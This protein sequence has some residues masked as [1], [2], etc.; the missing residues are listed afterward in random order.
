MIDNSKEYVICAAI[1]YKHKFRTP[2]PRGFIAQNLKEGMVIGQWRHGNCIYTHK[3]SRLSRCIGEEKQVQGFLT[4]KGNFVDRWQGMKIAYEAGQ[5]S[6][7]RAFRS[8]ARLDPD[9]I[10][11]EEL[12]S[13]PPQYRW[14]KMRGRYDMMYSEDL[15]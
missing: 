12:M 14:G 3:Q 4:S 9:A 15:Y 8:A 2:P 11:D 10:S 5:V 1:W 7:E 13:T 6:A